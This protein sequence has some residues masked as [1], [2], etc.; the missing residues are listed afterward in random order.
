MVELLALLA[1][2]QPGNQT[3]RIAI[4]HRLE[5]VNGLSLG[6]SWNQVACAAVLAV[7][8]AQARDGTVVSQLA[9]IPAGLNFTSFSADSASKQPNAIRGWRAA[10]EAGAKL[11]VGPARSA[12][13]ATVAELGAVDRIPSISY[14]ASSP[15][16]TDKESYALRCSPNHSC[17]LTL[18]SVSHP[19]RSVPPYPRA[20]S[21]LSV[22]H[23]NVPPATPSSAS[24]SFRSSTVSA[25]TGQISRLSMRT[26]CAWLA[27][28]PQR[29][30]AYVSSS[31]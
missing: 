30:A 12:V 25:G 1:L 8:H 17:Q 29:A 9:S 6:A 26:K 2:G 18:R 10:K 4:L 21:Q 13:A 22:L 5:G 23:E 20:R 15:S 11:V 3:H 14:W 31:S 7:R 16:L 24:F 19:S 28:R 27:S